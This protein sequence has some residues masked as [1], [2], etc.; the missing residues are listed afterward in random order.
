MQ[1]GASIGP[2]VVNYLGTTCI[3]EVTDTVSI[4]A[5]DEAKVRSTQL[6]PPSSEISKN[7]N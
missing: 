5:S 1:E 3:F 2:T 6:L 4:Q 7:L